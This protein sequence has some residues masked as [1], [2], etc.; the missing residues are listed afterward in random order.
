[1]NISIECYDK[2]YR[3][4][5]ISILIFLF[6]WFIAGLMFSS[7]EI[8]LW[9]SFY[10]TGLASRNIVISEFFSSLH[11][12]SPTNL[13]ILYVSISTNIVLSLHKTFLP[14]NNYLLFSLQE[15]TLVGISADFYALSTINNLSLPTTFLVFTTRFSALVYRNFLILSLSSSKE[16]FQSLTNNKC[17]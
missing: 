5:F 3:D 11:T 4:A 8:F 1:M 17:Y 7:I 6:S 12:I 10:F 15:T 14:P 9:K 2:L 16:R 13:N